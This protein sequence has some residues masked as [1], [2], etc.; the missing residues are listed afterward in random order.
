[1]NILQNITDPGNLNIIK[2]MF[3]N[4]SLV[5]KMNRMISEKFRTFRGV[6]Q[7]DSMT[8]KLFNV[9]V[10]EVLLRIDNVTEWKDHDY[11]FKDHGPRDTSN[12]QMM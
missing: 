12:M 6:P 7:D 8:P 4:T 9:Y 10:N 11:S 5:V 2:V 1:M 3:C